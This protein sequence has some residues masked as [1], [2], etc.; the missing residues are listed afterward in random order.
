LLYKIRKKHK[1]KASR[2]HHVSIC[3]PA[4]RVVA[5]AKTEACTACPELAEGTEVEKSFLNKCP[6]AFLLKIID[7]FIFLPSQIAEAEK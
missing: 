5:L 3:H 4:R 6:K 2:N 7:F 1:N